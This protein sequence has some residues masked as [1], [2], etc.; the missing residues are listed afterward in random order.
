MDNL[1]TLPNF[2]GIVAKSLN[3]A[4]EEAIYEKLRPIALDIVKEAAI[5]IARNVQGNAYW[6]HDYIHD[7]PVVMLRFN[8]EEIKFD[9][10]K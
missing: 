7:A 10:S 2:T 1:L 4:I 9:A 5:Q 6:R 3:S 8:S